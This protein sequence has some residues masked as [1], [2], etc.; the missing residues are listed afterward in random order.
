MLA[1]IWM[2][3]WFWVLAE[4]VNGGPDGGCLIVLM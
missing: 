3:E 1:E 4:V 2:T